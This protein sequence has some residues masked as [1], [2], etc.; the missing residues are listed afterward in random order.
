M[1]QSMRTFSLQ[2]SQAPRVLAPSSPRPGPSPGCAGWLGALALLWA[3]A[4]IL[5]P[6]SALGT[7]GRPHSTH[8]RSTCAS[9][10]VRAPPGSPCLGLCLPRP[11]LCREL[12]LIT[13]QGCSVVA[14]STDHCWGF[15]RTCPAASSLVSP[16]AQEVS[17]VPQLHEGQALGHQGL[18]SQA[19]TRRAMPGYRLGKTALSV[20]ETCG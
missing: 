6:G 1:G 18:R 5:L 8:S 20:C 19:G 11:G 3:T 2:G 4:G 17:R 13:S 14:G 16:R 15:A 9:S 12:P 7:H 10:A